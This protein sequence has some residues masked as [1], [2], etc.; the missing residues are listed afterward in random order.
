M[1]MTI[2]NPIRSEVARQQLGIGSSLFSAI[3]SRMGLKGR[4]LVILSHIQQWRLKNPTFSEQE[5]YHRPGCVCEPCLTKKADPNRSPRGRHRQ[6][7]VS[8]Q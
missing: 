6:L 7:V 3:K 2:E 1:S 5:V 8:G 4:K